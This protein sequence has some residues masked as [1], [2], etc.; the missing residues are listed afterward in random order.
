[1]HPANHLRGSKS[2]KLSGRKIVLAITGS[3]AAVECVKLC[4]ELIRHGADVHV[5]MSKDAQT[6]IHPWAMEFASGNP[7]TTGIDGRVQHVSFCG[8]VPDRADLLL[9]APATANTIS[10]IACGIDDT[11]VTTFATTALGGGMPVIL[12]PAMHGTMIGHKAVTE[13]IARLGKLGVKVL[14]P[15][16]EEHKAKMPEM[17]HIVA[18]VMAEIGRADLEGRRV[19]VIAGATEEPVDDIRVV[20]NRS[21]G[22]TGVELAKVAFERGAEVD[23]WMG[24]CSVDIPSYITTKRFTTFEQL[25]KLA[26]GIKHDVVLFPAAV[27]DYSP[28]K[29]PGKIPSDKE[30]LTVTLR[31]N[32]KLIDRM[33]AKVVVGFKAQARLDDDKLVGEARAL[34]KRSK[35]DFVVANRIE[36]VAPGK[37]RVFI[38]TE[39][40][41]TDE[42]EGTKSQVADRVLDVVVGML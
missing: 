25:A 8:D 18:E 27:S 7:V 33:K 16:M 3:I 11:A 10:K 40:G 30:R 5:V 37:T 35:C 29:V 4:R 2:D 34:L 28:E 24:R 1:M 19:L 17:E 22:E 21:S 38:V 6:I 26:K 39:S 23:L 32:P 41:A 31:R 15:R 42:I 36:Q 12:V 20:T 14:M 13:N 9:I